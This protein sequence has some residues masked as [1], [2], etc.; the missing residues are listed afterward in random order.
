MQ[1]ITSEW[2][3]IA[4]GD[5]ATANREM[6]VDID[7]NYKAVSFH[8]QQCGEKY[9]KAYLQERNLKPE[10]THSL[11]YLLNRILS[12][13]P[14]WA[15]LIEATLLLTEF[16]IDHRYPGTTTSEAEARESVRCAG[17]I[18]ERVRRFFSL[19]I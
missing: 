6:A 13:E 5:W 7:P 16:A 18:R 19:G 8:S 1:E 12:Y 17:Q 3:G 14:E 9:L 11:D 2:I 10:R 15:D 4:E